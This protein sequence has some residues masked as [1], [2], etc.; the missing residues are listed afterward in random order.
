MKRRILSIL[1]FAALV[2]GLLP[3]S[4]LSVSAYSSTDIAYA[5]EGGN[6]YFDAAT[7][8]ITDCDDTVTAADIPTEIDGV[9]VTSIGASAFE[10]CTMLESTTIP[11]SVTSIGDRGFYCCSA[12]S[13]VYFMG[14][15]PTIGESAF[16]ILNIL[17]DEPVIEVEDI[18]IYGLV[19]YYIGGNSGWSTPTWNDYSTE[20]WYG[21]DVQDPQDPQ[22]PPV[23]DESVY[24]VPGGN[25]YINSTTGMIY[26]CDDTVTYA[27]IPAEIGGIAVTGIDE[28]A[29]ANCSSLTGVVIPEGATSIGNWAFAGCN[30]MTSVTMP[31]SLA[32]IDDHA[33]SSCSSL[34]DVTI[35]NSVTSV[36]DSAFSGCTGLT[37]V[38]L[39]EGIT[40][41]GSAMFSGCDSL[42]SVTIPEGVTSIGNSAF[43]NC[44][45]LAGITI[46]ESVTSIGDGAFYFCCSLESV[47]IPESVTSIGSEAFYWCEG[48]DAVYFKGDAPAIGSCV[49]YT[50]DEMDDII[51]SGLTLY[52]I[53]GKEGWTSPTWNGY[54]T[55]TWDGVNMPE[56]ADEVTYP[57]EGGNLY[58]RKS[59][60]EI[61]DCDDTVTAANIPAK[62]D[63]VAVTSIG[64]WAFKACSSLTSVTIPDSVTSI[65]KEAFVSCSSLTNITIS[66]GMT[67]IG[68]YAFRYCKSLTS[69]N[70]PD[71]VKSIG[72]SAFSDC[73]SLTSVTIPEG[74]TS[75]G[76]EAFY[77]C[78]ALTSITIPGSVT[79]IGRRTFYTCTALTSVTVSEGVTS[80]GDHTFSGCSS[81]TSVKLPESLTSIGDSA[82]ACCNG[83]TNVKIPDGVTSIGSFAFNKCSSLTS[84][85][86]PGGVTSIGMCTFTNCGN[87]TSVTIS[88]GVTSIGDHAFSHCSSLT[89]VT[90]PDSVTSIG[91]GTFSSCSSLTSMTIPES[92][93][94]IGT[95]VFEN[96]CNLTSVTLPESITSIGYHMFIG[97][98]CLTSV[99]IPKG[100]T[101]IEER[102]FSGCSSLTSVTLPDGVTS[103][104]RGAFEASGLTSILLPDNVSSIDVV[105][106]SSCEALTQITV[107]ENNGT[108][109]SENGVLFDKEKTTLLV[110]PAGKAE[111]EYVFPNSVTGIGEYAFEGC[112]NLTSITL[113]DTI[114]K[115]DAS[116]FGACENLLDLTVSN[117]E[118]VI[119][120][121]N[122]LGVPG[123]TYVHGYAGST[124]ESFA[125]DYGYF[126]VDIENPETQEVSGD[127]GENVTWRYDRESRTLTISGS[128]AMA[129]YDKS[130]TLAPWL[131]TK[132]NQN[133]VNWGKTK[134]HIRSLVIE[135]G[136]TNIGSY[137]FLNCYD[138]ENVTISETV[139]HIGEGAFNSCGSLTAITIPNGVTEIGNK[140]FESCGLTELTL[141]DSV[142]SIG[143]YAFRYCNLKKVEFSKGLTSIGEGAFR[144]NYG[145]KSI[146][147]PTGVTNI[148]YEAFFDCTNLN[149]VYFMGDA[150]TLG[151]HTFFGFD[152]PDDSPIIGLTLYYIEGKAGWTTPTWKGYPTKIWDHLHAYTETVT[153]PTCT[154]QGYTTHTCE[155]GESYVDT[156]VDALGHD[157]GAWTQT[158]APTCT[159]KGE[160]QRTCSRCDAVETREIAAHGHTEVVDAAVAPTCTETGLT[161]GKH[162]SVCG[163][164][165]T[166]QEPVAALGHDYG[167]WTQTK[168]PTCTEKGEEKRT[169]S[170]CDAFEVR[171]IA[172]HG[173]T[174][175]IDPAVPAT[176]TETGKTEGKHCSV[177]GT[178]LVAQETV[179]ALGHDYGDWTQTKA[180]TCTEKGEEKRTCSR[181]DAFEVKEIA[182][183][184]H[185]YD[186]WTQTKEPT[187]TEKGEERRVCSRCDNFEM[188]EIAAHGHTEIVD[189][190]VPATCT[191]AGKTEGK[192]CSACGTVLIAQESI[193]ALGHDYG[194]WT[195]TKEPTCI[196]KGE[197]KRVCSR[198]DIFDTREIAA[199]GHNFDAWT[200]TKAPTCIEQGEEERDCSR[201][202]FFETRE[203]DVT[204][205]TEVIDPA[206]A[207]TCTEA[208]KTE[209][210]HCSVCGTVLVAQE[211]VDALGHDYGDWTQTKEPTCTEKG[212]EKRTCSRCDAFETRELDIVDPK[213]VVTAGTRKMYIGMSSEL[214]LEYAGEPEEILSTT[215]GYTWHVYGTE[216]YTD[217]VMAGV[218][219][220]KVVA[221]CASGADFSY[222]GCTAYGSVAEAEEGD[223]YYISILKDKTDNSAVYGILLTDNKFRVQYAATEAALAGESRVAFH[224]ANAFRVLHDASILE[225][226]DNAATAARLHSEDMAT[227]DYVSHTS[228]DGRLFYMRLKE[229]GVL[230]RYCSENLCAGYYSGI[231]AHNAWV[232]SAGHRT[233]L[234]STNIN[235]CGIGFAYGA[236]SY[237][238][239]Y[240]V[241]DYYHT[242]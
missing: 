232:N 131:H 122:T 16:R 171:E 99:S 240:A 98:S 12:L 238:L 220:N 25:I 95:S 214:L 190:A 233:N 46:P 211:T 20:L 148:G 91:I 168:V 192:H 33:F 89:S 172:A 44:F 136:V 30:S 61:Y 105:A 235:R 230:Y 221:I 160:E 85:T 181:C 140:A 180:P 47:T 201:C 110:Y 183:L 100:V 223:T 96:C 3:Q 197:E 84:V 229:N 114:S 161:E 174:E 217:F 205:H 216:T 125:N 111:T 72:D 134:F 242:K 149:A 109:S 8:T 75:I 138:L 11:E 23:I 107:G 158:V 1:L 31:E 141:A 53:E 104:G 5:V 209:G 83:L 231:G 51:I 129:D 115:V 93:T 123:L 36:G 142:T 153:A 77:N 26:A 145:L 121:G 7:G 178:V 143:D 218:Y 126:F 151:Y 188:R 165:L 187:C 241:T 222:R 40:S 199:L 116:A 224:M 135:S 137:A 203:L 70:I 179:A 56:P 79:T 60:G 127:C 202:G 50:M 182:A 120:A 237:Y 74:V 234:L 239:Y 177:C 124:A 65:G 169:C 34:T 94:S 58:F 206:V 117:P 69:I 49:F 41:I 45:S 28:S 208:G 57:V 102:A 150:P 155:C 19:L 81:L 167:A 225:W 156:Y 213:H 228:Q 215:S 6:I 29:F 17:Y 10:S 195:Q 194:T 38:T 175:V 152:S 18:N 219:E 52:Y 82:F 13:A 154:E 22:D 62:I 24:P 146:T 176:C 68:D 87:L 164:I 59:T 88:E 184:G 159:E 9:A 189:A 27:D 207:A 185:D 101:A 112:L 191:E 21:E 32:S 78:R 119:E 71:S 35:P 80:I 173:H 97:C 236:D 133:G 226:C 210:K 193:A 76:E 92:V 118:C 54:P 170:R 15:A 196:E 90:I 106:F 113:P 204:D 144:M 157:Y 42:T 66:E 163:T 227:N 37:S 64:G 162:C 39:P 200:Q 128:G 198:C 43:M 212:E 63:G 67:S 130:N 147:L 86:I 166:A 103:I 4:I 55:A 139:T 14:D 186:A 73:S 108:F 48:L 132:L 2:I